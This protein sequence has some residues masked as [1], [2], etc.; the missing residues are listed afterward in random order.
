MFAATVDIQKSRGMFY[1]SSREEDMS[2]AKHRTDPADKAFSLYV[3]TKASWN[4]EKCGKH[5]EPPT[6]S[7]H[8]SHFIG[9]GKENT[10]FDLDNACA[11]CFHCHQYFTSHPAE[12]LDW[13]T[14]RLGQQ[15][16]DELK[17]KSHL[18]CKKDRGSELIYWQNELSK[19]L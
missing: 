16:V 15:K 10:R 1:D 4:C 6:S 2:W 9:R 8:C 17:M 5:Y 7:L 18:Y 3:R 13:Q 19:L 11:L 12:H 14:E